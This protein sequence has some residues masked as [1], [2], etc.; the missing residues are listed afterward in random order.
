MTIEHHFNSIWTCKSTKF[1]ISSVILTKS[2][3]I[4]AS[5]INSNP[6][7]WIKIWIWLICDDFNFWITAFSEIYG[8]RRSVR[9]FKIFNRAVLTTW[10]NSISKL[11]FRSLEK[12]ISF[13]PNFPTISRLLEAIKTNCLLNGFF[14]VHQFHIS[15]NSNLSV[16]LIFNSLTLSK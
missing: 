8:P 3:D 14:P 5:V 13:Q 6:I 10:K 9:V 11:G 7:K 2:S 15:R 16:F 4:I 1:S 12:S